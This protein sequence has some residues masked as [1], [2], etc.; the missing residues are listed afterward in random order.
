MKG[1][2]K[3]LGWSG[4]PEADLGLGETET[5]RKIVRQLDQ[6][7]PERHARYVAAFAYILGRV[8]RAD[9]KVSE[10]E[11]A[12]MEHIVVKGASLP[13]EQA[14]LVVQSSG[15][16]DRQVEKQALRWDR[17]LPRD[18]G[19]QQDRF[20]SP[21]AS[22]STLPVRGLRCGPFNLGAGRQR[23]PSD[24]TGIASRPPKLH[25]HPKGVPG[26]SRRVEKTNRNVISRFG[27]RF[28]GRH[29]VCPVACSSQTFLAEDLSD[30]GRPYSFT[31]FQRMA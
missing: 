29:H 15:S 17:K 26:S 3:F 28:L 8:A 22:P 11:T 23:D 6:L 10:A 4:S 21:E 1:I 31:G 2:L 7:A 30:R 25:Q 14:I 16:G 13:T 24:F 18:Q 12:T 5:V 20:A 19:V 9:L 27:V